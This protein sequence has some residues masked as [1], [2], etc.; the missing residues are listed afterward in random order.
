MRSAALDTLRALA[1][2]VLWLGMIELGLRVTHVPIVGSNEMRDWQR[3]FRL[4]PGAQFW[5]ETE[6]WNHVRIN[7]LGFED[8]E[9]TLQRTPGTLRLAFLGSSY[10]QAPQ[11]AP[12]KAFPAVVER[13]LRRSKQLRARDVEALN[14]GVG[15]YG[16]PQQWI[17]LR[18]DV[19]KYDPQIVV[20]VIGLYNDIVNN[21]RYTT[22]SGR[23]YPYYTVQ[24]G[25]LIP[26]AITREQ[27]RPPDPEAVKWEGRMDDLMN[28]S[29]ILLHLH[30]VIRTFEGPAAWQPGLRIDP[31]Q[32]STFFPPHDPHLQNAWSVTEA[33]L[34]L[35][36][37]ECAIH[38]AEFWIVVIDFNLQTE[39]DPKVRAERIR[40]FGITDLHY[41]DR[42]IIEFARREGIHN[43]WLAP[44]LAEYAESHRTALHGFFNTPENFGH[45]NLLGHEIVGSFIAGE[46]SQGSERLKAE[47]N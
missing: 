15:G 14:F 16:L 43:F 37:K 10:L 1:V 41:P 3:S 47:A 36:R 22:V 2:V 4:R 46:L 39:P 5:F 18:D 33:S 42:R 13:E 38:N 17:T 44:L 19:W 40:K 45:Y 30:R 21:D 25:Q 7:S 28:Y 23:T 6:G 20:E 31:D 32:T 12:E 27:Q 8:S 29:T 34:K 26:D 9:R 11:V 24:D 35:M